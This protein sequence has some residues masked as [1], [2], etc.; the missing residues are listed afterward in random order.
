MFPNR[1]WEQNANGLWSSREPNGKDTARR[2]TIFLA[3]TLPTQEQRHEQ[4]LKLMDEVG[5]DRVDE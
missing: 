4:W 2:R 5:R 3:L 1:V